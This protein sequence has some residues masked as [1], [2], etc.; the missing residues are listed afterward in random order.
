[1]L[2]FTARQYLFMTYQREDQNRPQVSPGDYQRCQQ[3]ELCPV[4]FA[5]NQGLNQHQ[6]SYEE[7]EAGAQQSHDANWRKQIDVSVHRNSLLTVL[8][9]NKALCVAK[10]ATK[11]I[12]RWRLR[13]SHPTKQR[14]H[15]VE[16]TLQRAATGRR[17]TV[18]RFGRA[19]RESLCAMNVSGFL[20]FA[21]VYAQ[22]AVSCLDR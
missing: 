16:I 22:I 8:D 6:G 2:L 7:E 21:R 11:K 15:V 14:F 4:A 19:A 10:Q 17:Q 13:L 9:L 3:D 20:E 12:S 1:M 18:F 5:D